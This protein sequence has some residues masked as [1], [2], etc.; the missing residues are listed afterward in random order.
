MA[1]AWAQ[2]DGYPIPISS[3]RELPLWVV[4]GCLPHTVP[5]SRGLP[6]PTHSD[7][8][9]TACDFIVPNSSPVSSGGERTNFIVPNKEVRSNFRIGDHDVEQCFRSLQSL[10]GPWV[11]PF[12]CDAPSF[13]RGLES[14]EVGCAF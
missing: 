12:F 9:S 2:V 4:S 6:T 7:R 1:A 14:P 11:S 8:V 5:V 10:P 3:H 13:K